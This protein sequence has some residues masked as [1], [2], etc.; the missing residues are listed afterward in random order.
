MA[1]NE[2]LG[3]I[4]QALRDDIEKSEGL[5]ELR[6]KKIASHALSDLQQSDSLAFIFNH[7]TALAAAM[8]SG[9]IL[10]VLAVPLLI[11]QR[12]GGQF[13]VEEKAPPSEQ[14]MIAS[15]QKDQIIEPL[16][17][18]A[19]K[20][21]SSVAFSWEGSEKKV[22]KISRSSSPKDFS[23]A[24]TVMVAGNEWTDPLK[25]GSNIIYYKIE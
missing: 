20:T 21:D 1:R 9:F 13:L 2:R 17:I 18:E 14:R 7:R 19:R 23:K 11:Q 4:A 15:L 24:Y 10:I 16:Q 3:R 5:S 25:D 6:K 12:N 22:Y 8:V